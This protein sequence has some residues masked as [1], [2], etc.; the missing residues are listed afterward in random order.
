M[1][2]AIPVEIALFYNLVYNSY[3]QSSEMTPCNIIY[4]YNNAN[5]YHIHSSLTVFK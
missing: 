2:I 1:N 5:T 3:I 4:T